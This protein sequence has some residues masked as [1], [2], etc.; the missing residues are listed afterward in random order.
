MMDC[1]REAEPYHNLT[2]AAEALHDVGAAR[3]EGDLFG[4]VQRR[5]HAVFAE[6]LQCKGREPKEKVRELIQRR[7]VAAEALAR[8]EG[9]RPGTQPA[10]WTLPYGEPAWVEVPA[11]E[12]WMG[13][14]QGRDREKPIHQLYVEAFKIAKVPVTNAQYQ[15]GR[16]HV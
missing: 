15:I 11:G 8:V 13:S 10:F 3:T 4:E 12:F 5:L 1:K 14:E 2:L 6:P 16:A 9:G 7:A